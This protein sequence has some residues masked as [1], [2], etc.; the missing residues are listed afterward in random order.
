MQWF[1][2]ILFINTSG[3]GLYNFT[4]A[5]NAQLHQWD[6]EEGMA[7]L[8]VQHTSAS[9]VINENYARSAKTDMEN[10]LEHIAPEGETWYAHTLEG[11]DDSPAHLRTMLTHTSLEIPVDN[12]LLS[13][14][15]WQGIY[16][17]EHRDAIHQRRVLLR[18]LSTEPS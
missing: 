1:K 14:G 7:Y 17:A 4:N 16:L 18:V 8:F 2:S 13:L 9:L 15:T 5:I 6:V 11:K 3:K 10:F 12:G